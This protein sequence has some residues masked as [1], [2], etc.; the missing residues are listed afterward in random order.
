[1]Q[2]CFSDLFRVKP[3][4]TLTAETERPDQQLKRTLGPFHLTSLGV[5]AIVGAGIFS[6]VGTAAAGGGDHIGAGP[7][8]V[9]SFV[10]V[11]VACGFAALCYAEFASMVPVAG[12]AYTYAYATLGQLVAWIIGWD[13]ILEYAVGNIAVALSWSDYFQTLLRTFHLDWPL[14]LGTDYRSATQAAQAVAAAQA[15]N[16]LGALDATVLLDAKAL[17]TAPRFAGVPIVFDLPAVLIVAGLTWILVRG[18]RESARFNTAMVLLKLA[19]VAIFVGVGA[20][21]IRPE[22]WHPFAPTGLAG[23]KSAAG[24]VFFAYIGFDAVSTAAEETKEPQRNMPIGIIGSLILCTVL[25]IAVAVVLTGMVKSSQLSGTADPL[26]QA[27][28]IRG[29]NWMAGIIAFGA[30]FATTSVLLVFQLGQPRILFSMARD[31]LLPQWASRV[32]PRFRTPHLATLLTGA[33]VA[34]AAAVSN[35]N[36]VADVC[37]IGTLF[38]FV[39]VAAGIIVLRWVDP[40]R[41]RP[42]RTPLFP[43]VPLLAI[44]SCG[45]IMAQLPRAAW[46]RFGIWLVLGLIIYFGYSHRHARKKWSEGQPPEKR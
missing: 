5:G 31:G 8:V 7:A 28:K 18:I 39:L 44:A 41:E 29:L 9:L 12:S 4:E 43:W 6:M 24:A 27:F 38:A 42:F 25:Y 15:T 16:G 36:E 11:A 30:V 2:W 32:H 19:I 20:A 37:S 17:T 46:L 10:L 35:I 14:W 34:G 3:L 22:N 1:V 45:W 26:A 21:Y 23:I 40:Q 13:L 33:A